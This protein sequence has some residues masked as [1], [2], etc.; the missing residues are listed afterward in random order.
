VVSLYSFRLTLRSRTAQRADSGTS[1]LCFLRD[2]MALGEPPLL[3]LLPARSAPFPMLSEKVAYYWHTSKHTTLSMHLPFLAARC[4][5][6][7]AL[8]RTLCG[9]PFRGEHPYIRTLSVLQLHVCLY[10]PLKVGKKLVDFV[11]PS[12]LS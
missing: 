3:K 8:Y 12:S 4:W 7:L 1:T 10:N 5:Y 6:L 9:V 2:Q 11:P